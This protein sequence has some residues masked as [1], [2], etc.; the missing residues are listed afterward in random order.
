MPIKV[1]QLLTLLSY[2]LEGE[3]LWSS[4]SAVHPSQ[5]PLAALSFVVPE[6]SVEINLKLME[7]N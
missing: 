2:V 4:F 6:V 7:I 1:K 5:K 3:F